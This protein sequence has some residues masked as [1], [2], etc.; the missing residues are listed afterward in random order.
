MFNDMRKAVDHLAEQIAKEEGLDDAAAAQEAG[1][2]VRV[3]GYAV[4]GLYQELNEIKEALRA[5]AARG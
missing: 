2:A 4:V 5:I 3:A 1:R